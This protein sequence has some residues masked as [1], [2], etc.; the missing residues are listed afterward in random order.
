MEHT[1]SDDATEP[2]EPTVIEG[3]LAD[4]G[5]LEVAPPAV[6]VDYTEAGVPTFDY[7]RDR[8]ANRVATATGATELASDSAASLDEQFAER[9][10]AA[11]EKLEEIRRSLRGE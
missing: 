1:M 2:D 9:D 6:P 4:G 5:A 11:R 10:R 7:A 8:I 3:E